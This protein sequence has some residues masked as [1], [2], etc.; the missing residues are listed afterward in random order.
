[1]KKNLGIVFVLFLVV[2]I[3]GF[4]GTKIQKPQEQKTPLTNDHVLQGLQ[5]ELAVTATVQKDETTDWKT[6]DGFIPLTGNRFIVGTRGINGLGKY[7]DIEQE[8]LN[9]I[10]KTF[11]AGIFQKTDTYFANQGFTKNTDNTTTTPG[12]VNELQTGYEKDT[13]RCVITLAIAT[14]PFGYF[15]CGE[16]DTK[17]LILIKQFQ[18]VVNPDNDPNLHI[19][20]QKVENDFA[21]GYTSNIIGSQWIAK[22]TA[23]TWQVVWTGQEIPFCADMDKYEIPASIYTN[24]L[25]DA[26]TPRFP[27]Q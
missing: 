15:F 26:T 20:V 22:K 27:V 21:L 3:I 24:C 10:D 25:L 9:Q 23:G 17:Q 16:V 18:Q 19:R 4:I 2:L 7:G 1:M 5:K 8:N 12:P 13:M 14:D 6:A 11:L